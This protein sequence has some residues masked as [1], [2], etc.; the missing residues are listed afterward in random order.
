MQRHDSLLPEVW[1]MN[2]AITGGAC[3]GHNDLAFP[4]GPLKHLVCLRPPSLK[5]VAPMDVYWRA[6]R[7]TQ[8]AHSH[9]PEPPVIAKWL[10][11]NSDEATGWAQ[12]V[13][14]T[15]V[16]AAATAAPRARSRV[17]KVPRRRSNPATNALKV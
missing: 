14:L 11:Q 16:K 7:L 3:A 9:P 10:A 12:T 2:S 17:S 8:D 4:Q 5:I 15:H 6:R 1:V 13:G